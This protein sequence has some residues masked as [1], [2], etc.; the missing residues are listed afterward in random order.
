MR[1]PEETMPRNEL[2][3]M[4]GH[5]WDP[6]PCCASAVDEADWYRGRP[7]KQTVCPDCKEL[8]RLGKDTRRRASEAGEAIFKW[9]KRHHDWPGYYGRY[10]FQHEPRSGASNGP[11]DAG[12]ALRRRMFDLVN[13]LGRA[14]EG[15]AWQSDAPRVLTCEE[16]SCRISPYEGELL[17]TMNPKV[18]ETLDALDAAVRKALESAYREGKQRGQNILVNLARNEMTVNEFNRQTAEDA[19]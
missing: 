4:R 10:H 17:M 6:W 11:Y 12:D 18:R 13:T 2:A 7:K 16:R 8:I 19:D 14:A 15:H 3:A 1:T 9:P 5:T